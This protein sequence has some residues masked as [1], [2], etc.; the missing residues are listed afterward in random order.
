MD[1]ASPA[2]RNGFAADLSTA[3]ALSAR[4]TTKKTTDANARIFGMWCDFVAK[5]G[6]SPSLGEVRGHKDKLAYIL[7][8]ALRC[9]RH[10]RTNK[11]V[12]AKSVDKALLAVGQGIADLGELD[13]RKEAVG[14]KQYHPVY[15]AFLQRLRD[16]DD[17][18]SRVYPAN[19]SIL[20]AL[21]DAL[22]TE[23]ETEGVVNQVAIDL[24]IIGFYWMLRPSEY[25]QATTKEARSQAFRFCDITL[26]ID[27]HVH[28]GP[29]A[30]LNDVN[31]VTFATLTF[32]DQ[33]NA[34]RGEQIGHSANSDPTL[35][36]VKALA[37][38]ARRLQLAGASPQDPIH[39][40]RNPV[41]RKWHPVPPTFITNALRHAATAIQ[42]Q[43]GIDPFLLSARSLRPGGATALLCANVGATTVQLIGRWKSDAMLRYLRV[44]AQMPNFSQL[45][46]THGS[47]TFNPGALPRD[48]PTPD[49]LLPRETPTLVR[50]WLSHAE[51]Y[52]E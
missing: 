43:T 34:V 46:L 49:S 44:Q 38:I 19:V 10:G 5:L 40:H 47:F 25:L 50:D 27:G 31:T 48:G 18:D 13:P 6:R 32:T 7:V 1:T 21:S 2:A 17:P 15:R 29:T 51:M 12:R 39:Y 3:L 37:R 9:R 23:H 35:C 8:F 24:C 33:K 26:T 30:P 28:P 11:S 45:M 36:P 41:T 22:D 20:R 4:S 14:S 16:E 52:E 42:E